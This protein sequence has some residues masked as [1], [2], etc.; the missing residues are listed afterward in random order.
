VRGFYG[1][2]R[3]SHD[4]F[5]AVAKVVLGVVVLA[6]LFGDAAVVFLAEVIRVFGAAI[7]A[8]AERVAQ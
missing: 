2:G 8:L 4:L 7:V 6:L 1:G 5:G 3:M